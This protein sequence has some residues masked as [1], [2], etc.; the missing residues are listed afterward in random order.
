MT[1]YPAPCEF[2]P[3]LTSDRLAVIA[4]G[5]LSVLEDTYAELDTVY[6]DNYTRATCTFGRQRNYL[7]KLW[8]DKKYD[9]MGI[10]NSAMDITFEIEGVPIRFFTDD[11]QNPKK[12]GFF[13]R[14][15][16]DQLWAPEETT[17]TLWRFVVEKPEFENEGAQVHLVGYN[18]LGE[19]ISKWEYGEG[20]VT[21]LHSTDET[22]PEAAA[23]ELPEIS[24][25]S[26]N[27]DKKPNIK[28]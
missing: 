8:K 11:P 7:L 24:A 16:V 10:T 6:D 25:A 28:E 18:P 20:A 2:H 26:P 17:P 3:Q 5:L 21:V 23:I 22:V 12:P 27:V 14:N 1:Q 15:S 19:L 4:R 9:W 13:R